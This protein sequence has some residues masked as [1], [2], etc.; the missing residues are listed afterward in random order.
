MADPILSVRDLHTH[1]FADEGVVRA[2]ETGR[3][4]YASL[5]AELGL[6][7]LPSATNFVAIDLGS[8]ERATSAMKRLL[9]EEAVFVRMP[10][11]VSAWP[12]R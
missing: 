5:A 6:K 1:F 3:R 4:D 11:A 9:E 10:G 12:S 8:A 2:V 7:T